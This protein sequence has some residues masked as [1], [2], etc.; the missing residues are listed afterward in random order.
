[1][2]KFA[3]LE[4]EEKIQIEDK[5]RLSGI[6]SFISVGASALDAVTIK[7]G[8]DESAISVFNTNQN[9]WFLD[10]QFEIFNGDFDATNNKLDFSEDGGTTEL[11]ATITPGTFTLATLATEVQTQLNAEGAFTYTVTV[12]KDDRFTIISTGN[13]SLLPNEG[14]NS[15]TSILPIIGYS[16]KPGFDDNAF[17]NETELKGLKIRFLPKAITLSVDDS[18]TPVTQTRFIK[19]YSEAGD[20]LFSID[21]DLRTKKSDVLNWIE[22]GRNTFI[23][24]HREAQREILEFVREEGIVDIDGNPLKLKD[25]TNPSDLRLWSTFLT[26]RLILD[27]L[28]NA[29][30]DVFDEDARGF[31]SKEMKHRKMTFLR[32]DFDNDGRSDIGEGIKNRSVKLIRQ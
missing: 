21:A 2:A 16:S 30:G 3:H 23:K 4:I 11:T 14:S 1:M 6:K 12:D 28:S 22:Q 26:L 9:L 24:F 8:A 29:I 13:T 5:T 25:F 15:E 18:T 17:S 10:W 20:A 31:E 7:P 32:V 19:L 27:D